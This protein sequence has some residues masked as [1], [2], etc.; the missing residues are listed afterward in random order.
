[1]NEFIALNALLGLFYIL[2]RIFLREV[3]AFHTNRFLLLAYPAIGSFHRLLQN[4][5]FGAFAFP[6]SPIAGNGSE[7]NNGLRSFPSSTG[8]WSYMH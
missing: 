5:Q 7:F 1:M 3:P 6:R 4:T 2:H 8:L